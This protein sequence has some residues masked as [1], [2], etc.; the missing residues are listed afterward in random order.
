MSGGEEKSAVTERNA[1]EEDKALILAMNRL[2]TE[3]TEAPVDAHEQEEKKYLVYFDS[4][5]NGRRLYLVTDDERGAD[6]A[7]RHIGK[8][9]ELGKNAFVVEVAA[10]ALIAETPKYDSSD[11]L[12]RDLWW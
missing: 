8:Y 3:S 5:M 2:I 7:R 12:Y 4:P 9:F 10:D 11:A 1:E 6:S